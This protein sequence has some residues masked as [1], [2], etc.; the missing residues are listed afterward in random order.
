MD[1]AWGPSAKGVGKGKGMGMGKGAEAP[2]GKGFAGG[3]GWAPGPSA[4]PAAAYAPSARHKEMESDDEWAEDLET[5]GAGPDDYEL[6]QRP[7]VEDEEEEDR[8]AREY[9]TARARWETREKTKWQRE[10]GSRGYDPTLEDDPEAWRRGKTP[11]VNKAEWRRQNF[12]GEFW[13]EDRW[14]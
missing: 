11:W 9:D 8:W 4:R 2:W 13:D 5:D 12:P 7:I 6:V 10:A 3:K 1:Q 14:P